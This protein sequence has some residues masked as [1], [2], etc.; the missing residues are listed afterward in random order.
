MSESESEP[1]GVSK[2][3]QVRAASTASRNDQVLARRNEGA[4]VEL[5]DVARG[6]VRLRLRGGGVPPP[7]A[8]ATPAVTTPAVTTPATA[9]PP[10]KTSAELFPAD[11]TEAV[12]SSGTFW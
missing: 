1:H 9:P 11:G 10:V 2:R 8:V 6:V 3:R 7:P 5:D 4:V 12:S